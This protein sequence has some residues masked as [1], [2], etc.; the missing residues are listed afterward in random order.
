MPDKFAYPQWYTE[1]E[2]A[3][4]RAAAAG[5]EPPYAGGHFLPPDPEAS[6]EAEPG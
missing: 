3:A 2:Q 4:I 1:A 6:P 5:E